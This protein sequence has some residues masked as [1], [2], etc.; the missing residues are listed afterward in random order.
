MPEILDEIPDEIPDAP[1]WWSVIEPKR[2]G[3]YARRSS[4]LNRENRV[5]VGSVLGV[6]AE[7]LMEGLV[8]DI[9]FGEDVLL[10]E[11][12]VFETQL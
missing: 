4:C 5:V 11:D 1:P 2:M 7:G 10:G 3:A 12:I 9:L 8:D 6:L